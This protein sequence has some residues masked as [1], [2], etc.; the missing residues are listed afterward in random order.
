MSN[1]SSLSRS[2]KGTKME[3]CS[4]T[5]CHVSCYV[6]YSYYSPTSSSYGKAGMLHRIGI[7]LYSTQYYYTARSGCNATVVIT[8]SIPV[9]SFKLVRNQRQAYG[10]LRGDGPYR[11]GGPR[12]RHEGAAQTVWPGGGPQEG[13]PQEDR[14]RNQRGHHP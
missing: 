4:S 10:R 12:D 3:G 2:R 1:I 8:G 13:P 11:G 5:K 14:G 7:Y 6:S 9:D